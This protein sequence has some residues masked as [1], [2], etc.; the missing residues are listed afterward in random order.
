MNASATPVASAWL[1]SG[2]GVVIE[3]EEEE[4]KM[5]LNDIDTVIFCTG[6]SLNMDMLDP[7]LRFDVKGPFFTDY[8]EL[9]KQ[10]EDWKMTK[11]HL[12]KDFGDV[13][14]G[15]IQSYC[16]IHSEIYRGHLISNTNMMFI[17]D[18]LDTPL[19]DLDVQ[20]WLLIA[21]IT[22][23]I[24]LPSEKEMKRFNLQALAGI[25][26]RIAGSLQTS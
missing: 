22:G 7:S 12:T 20:A 18:R 10:K 26:G 13:P 15:K 16:T 4:H 19:L 6:Y 1:S 25:D 23:D 5:T 14:I 8:D 3:N 9:H 21:H 11:N 17:A 2:R 24:T